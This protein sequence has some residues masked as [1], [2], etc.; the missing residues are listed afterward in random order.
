MEIN[1]PIYIEEHRTD[2]TTEVS[3]HAWPIFAQLLDQSHLVERGEKIHTTINKL[4]KNLRRF[5]TEVGE[6]TNQT[7]IAQFSYCPEI[8]EHL[9]KLT[10]DLGYRRLPAKF[11]FVT[12]ETFGRRVAFT[13]SVPLVWFEIQRGEIL[14]ERAKE[15]LTKH[16]QEE[17]KREGR[18]TVNLDYVSVNGKAWT[19]IIE[20]DIHLQPIPER[21]EE[22]KRVALA[23]TEK[24]KG[25]TELHRV[26]RCLD[27][28]YPDELERVSCRDREI[29]ELTQLLNMPDQR[30][31]LLVGP[32]LVGKTALIHAYV[33]Q[34]VAARHSVYAANNN[35]WLVSPQRLISGMSYVGQWQNRLLAILQEVKR[36]NHILYFDDLLGL[37]LAGISTNSQL[38]VADVLKPYIETRTVRILAEITPEAFQILQE[39]DRSWADLFQIVRISETTEEQTTQI[40]ISAMRN[41][42][43]Q[44]HCQFNIDALPTTVDLQYRYARENAFPGKATLFLRQ[45]AIKYQHNTIDRYQVMHEFQ[46]KSGLKLAFLDKN[47]ALDR[48]RIISFLASEV[49]GQDHAIE[50]AADVLCLAKARLN[51]PHRPLASLLFLG[52]TGVGKTQLAKSI[53]AFIFGG[54]DK[55]LRFDM[56]E[57]LSYDAVARLV[58]TFHQPEGLLTSAVRRQPFCVLL[59]DEIEKAHPDVFNLLLQVMGEGRL[60][61]ALGRTADFSNVIL[62]M[63]SNLGVKEAAGQLGFQPDAQTTS[64]IYTRAAEKFFKPEFFNRLDRLI[65]F[66]NLTRSQIERIAHLILTQILNREGFVRRKCLPLIY[67]QAMESIIDQGYHPQLGARALK[68]ALEQQLS[69]PVAAQLTKIE[70]NQATILNLYTQ[71]GQLAI[72]IQT[73]REAPRQEPTLDLSNPAKVV[74]AIDRQLDQIEVEISHLQPHHQIDTAQIDPQIYH[75][76]MIKDQIRKIRKIGQRVLERRPKSNLTIVPKPSYRTPSTLPKH[77][78]LNV[79]GE[80]QEFKSFLAAADLTVALQDL[81]QEIAGSAEFDTKLTELLTETAWL[82]SIIT[83]GSQ[84]AYSEMAICISSPFND[85]PPYE[86]QESYETLLK[87]QFGAEV[88][89]IGDRDKDLWPNALI[90]QVKS[91]YVLPLLKVEEGLHL[92]TKKG[93]PF[94]PV[95]VKILPVAPGE[96]IRKVVKTYVSQDKDRLE[97]LAQGQELD[98][99]FSVAELFA[100]P[101]VLRIYDAQSSTLDLRTGLVIEGLP[102]ANELRI[103]ILKAL[104]ISIA[105]KL[106]S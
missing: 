34:T 67:P 85:Y 60:T 45:L 83:T 96:D 5:L 30:P 19:T 44:H 92:F 73:L 20:L 72:N 32:H 14:A 9:L 93:R 64:Q 78:K 62:I 53:A 43:K 77:T 48:K 17:E 16:Y 52:T 22:R 6:R 100:L 11:L 84:P 40:L 24:L 105:P 104:P 10:I 15:V 35:V 71:A 95:E 36:R 7:L 26:G 27:W 25:E 57:F 81:T 18:N 63:T 8:E 31:I 68:R 69:Q 38:C 86:W 29:A 13:P 97:K 65:P 90:F 82:Q 94:I 103:C 28:L 58:G 1:I 74:A 70:I 46:A 4:V 101:P 88:N 66:Q 23:D 106:L 76:F 2:E 51:D 79:A 59:L 56:N 91:S 55:I 49:I 89:L 47:I 98:E 33:Y 102:G 21:K 50:V 12:F 61:D 3:Y 39:K 99:S 41:L 37:F 75:Y 42:E 80:R 54:A 87:R